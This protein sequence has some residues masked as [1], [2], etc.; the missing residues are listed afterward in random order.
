VVLEKEEMGFQA[1]NESCS[2]Q[3]LEG[4]SQPG[5]TKPCMVSTEWYCFRKKIGK[6]LGRRICCLRRNY[7]LVLW[8]C[9]EIL[10]Q[11]IDCSGKGSHPKIYG[12]YNIYVIW[13][14]GRHV[15]DYS[16][17]SID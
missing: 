2:R 13:P 15:L 4:T 17:T 1:L 9:R 5:A 8:W 3:P 10:I 7:T 6:I 16:I 12:I 14:Q 11:Q